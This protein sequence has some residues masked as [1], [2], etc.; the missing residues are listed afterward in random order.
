MVFQRLQRLGDGG[1]GDI[2]GGGC[3]AHRAE[4]RDGFES[5]QQTQGRQTAQLNLQLNSA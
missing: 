2:Q 4:P 1:L 3:L 5:G